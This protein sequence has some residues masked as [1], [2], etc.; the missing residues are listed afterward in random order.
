MIVGT[1]KDK[2]STRLTVT[3]MGLHVS[4]LLV[5]HVSLDKG[6]TRLTVTGSSCFFIFIRIKKGEGQREKKMSH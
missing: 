2:G 4:Q 6:S 1:M 3:I 5:V